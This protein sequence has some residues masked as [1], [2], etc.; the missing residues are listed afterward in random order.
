[1]DNNERS[2]IILIQIKYRKRFKE[3]VARPMYISLYYF[4]VL[5]LKIHNYDM[6]RDKSLSLSLLMFYVTCD[7]ITVIY[8]TA[9]MCRR[10]EEEDEVVPTVGLPTP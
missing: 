6:T 7:D 9:Q 2:Q 3:L 5:N 1:M 10:T 4:I 8:L